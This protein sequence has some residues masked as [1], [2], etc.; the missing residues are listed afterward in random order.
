MTLFINSGNLEHKNWHGFDYVINRILPNRE[1]AVIEVCEGGW[2]WRSV[3]VAEMR[4][5]G[6][7]MMLRIPRDLIGVKEE[8]LNLQFKWADHYVADDIW[9]FYEKGDAAP[10]G[11]LTYI[12]SETE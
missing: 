2:N 8:L 11:R 12:F 1:G 10:I 4:V 5:D 6:N 7:Q 3:G 9:S